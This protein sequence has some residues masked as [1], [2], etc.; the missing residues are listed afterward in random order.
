MPEEGFSK[1]KPAIKAAR[2]LT[3]EGWQALARARR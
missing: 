1:K 2:P 3:V